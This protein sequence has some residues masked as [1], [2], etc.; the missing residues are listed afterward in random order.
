MGIVSTW[1]SA[2][3]E[4]FEATHVNHLDLSDKPD[5]ALAE[6]ITSAGRVSDKT[7]G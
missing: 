3:A 4:G 7:E 1:Q 5:G 2:H 6:R